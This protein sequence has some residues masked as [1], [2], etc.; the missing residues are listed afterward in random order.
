VIVANAVLLE[1]TA[2]VTVRI[3]VW[4]ALMLAGAVYNPLTIDPT[5]GFSDQITVVF[6][7]PLTDA[8]NCPICPA[9]RDTLVGL[10]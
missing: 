5:G 8:A 3:T 7:V 1:S 9:F 10:T 6:V 4:V 2:L